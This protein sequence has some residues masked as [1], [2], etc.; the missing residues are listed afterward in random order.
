MRRS[1]RAF[2]NIMI[3]GNPVIA[4]LLDLRK[5]AKKRIPLYIQ[6]AC[7]GSTLEFRRKKDFP[8]EDLKCKCGKIYLIKW[9]QS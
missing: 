2:R 4:K 6:A 7:C 8:L 9:E 5:A 1:W 3:K